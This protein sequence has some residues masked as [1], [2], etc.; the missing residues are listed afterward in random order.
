[1][2]PNTRELLP[3]PETP[4]N[5]VSRRF[6]MSTLT[7]LRLLTRAP[8]TRIRS[9]ASAACRAEASASVLV[10]MLIGTPSIGRGR[11]R[12]VE[13]LSTGPSPGRGMRSR[14]AD[15]NGLPRKSV[16][17][18]EGPR[19]APDGDAVRAA[20]VG[21]DAR[22]LGGGAAPVERE[23]H[24]RVGGVEL[25][26]LAAEA[27]GDGQAVL[28]VEPLGG[29]DVLHAEQQH[30]A[31]DV[32][33]GRPGVLLRRRRHLEDGAVRRLDDAAVAPEALGH[34]LEHRRAAVERTGDEAVDGARPRHHERQREATEA[35]GRR[36]RGADTQ[37]G[38]ETE[39]GAVEGLGRRGVGDVEDD[40]LDG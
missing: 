7:S 18:G 10:A 20:A 2:V 32:P 8:S 29:L 37:T 9:W 5:T 1:M 31:L 12:R 14:G 33:D 17:V 34:R 24:G 11:R 3:D 13:R 25:D 15:R 26:V 22:V 40:G 39:G 27:L 30:E 28:D 6:G 23:P 16:G 19:V 21:A 4:V 38:V 36:L 35:G